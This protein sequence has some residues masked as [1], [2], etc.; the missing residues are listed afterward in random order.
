MGGSVRLFG[1]ALLPLLL[2]NSCVNGQEL[3]ELPDY[4]SGYI[5]SIV[6]TTVP[7]V[8]GSNYF[9]HN[10]SKVSFSECQGREGEVRGLEIMAV[11]FA[12]QKSRRIKEENN[13]LGKLSFCTEINA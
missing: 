5:E 8:P 7:G 9:A 12:S 10:L 6:Q 3:P 11:W 4:F 2:L 1:V 13:V